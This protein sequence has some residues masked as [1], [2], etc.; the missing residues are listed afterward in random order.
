MAKHGTA[1]A[2]SQ[3]VDQD[4]RNR[5]VCRRHGRDPGPT[6]SGIGF[7]TPAPRCGPWQGLPGGLGPQPTP[8]H[9]Y[10]RLALEVTA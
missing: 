7:A 5:P 10:R 6:P 3:L 1:G 9:S 2:H 8:L 4:A